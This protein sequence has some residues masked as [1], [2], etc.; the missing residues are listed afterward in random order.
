MDKHFCH[1]IGAFFVVT[2]GIGRNFEFYRHAGKDNGIFYFMSRFFA[3]VL[4]ACGI[5]TVLAHIFV[6]YIVIAFIGELSAGLAWQA[7]HVH[8]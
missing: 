4:R 2:C 3:A 6:A 8:F 1:F 5:D 7:L